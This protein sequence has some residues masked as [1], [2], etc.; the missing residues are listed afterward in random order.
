MSNFR[1][2]YIPGG[3]YFFTFVTY[4]RQ[5]IFADGNRVQQLR[6]SFREVKAIAIM[7][8]KI[9]IRIFT[10]AYTW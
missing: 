8:K 6:Q 4:G 10:G 3:T 7:K 1:C 2:V 5:P 9:F